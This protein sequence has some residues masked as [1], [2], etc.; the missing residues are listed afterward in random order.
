MLTLDRVVGMKKKKCFIFQKKNVFQKNVSS[1]LKD[2]YNLEREEGEGFVIWTKNSKPR[3][4][5][6]KLFIRL[7]LKI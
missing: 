5:S 2:Y 4:K 3:R 6:I 1:I 7:N